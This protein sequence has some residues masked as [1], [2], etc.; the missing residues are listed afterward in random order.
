MAEGIAKRFPT[1]RVTV[2]DTDPEMV[3][4]ARRRLAH[5]E[6]VSV[7]H[8]DVTA[9]PFEGGSFEHVVS[10]LMLHHVIGWEQ[11]LRE[12]RRVLVPGGRFSGYDLHRGRLAELIHVVDRSPYRLIR[13]EEFEHGLHAA[14]FNEI[15]VTRGLGGLLTR[16]VATAGE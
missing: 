5:I 1:A 6:N 15:R 8:A 10:Y 3:E 16:F 9:L 11:A 14:G 13:H 4:A 12:A 7:G 2:T